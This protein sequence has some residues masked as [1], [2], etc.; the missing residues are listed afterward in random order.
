[1]IGQRARIVSSWAQ[2]KAVNAPPLSAN[3]WMDRAKKGFD[4]G[5]LCI[6]VWVYVRAVVAPARLINEALEAP[7]KDQRVPAW[8]YGRA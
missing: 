8:F 5:G 4:M 3:G 7:G 1:M 2:K 6:Y